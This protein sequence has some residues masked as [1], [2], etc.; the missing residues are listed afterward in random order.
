MNP[1]I[2]I[3]IAGALLAALAVPAYAATAMADT[4]SGAKAK[5]GQQHHAQLDS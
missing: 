2:K 1:K 5:R 3:A 4:D